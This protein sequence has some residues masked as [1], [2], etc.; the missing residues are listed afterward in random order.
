MSEPCDTA[1]DAPQLTTGWETETPIEDT[2]MR[3]AVFTLTGEVTSAAE[4]LGGRVARRP[5]LIAADL[6]RPAAFYNSAILLRPLTPERLE[7]TMAMLDAFF[8]RG[9]A[10]TGMVVLFSL[11]PTPDLRPFGW[12]LMG[13]PPIHLRPPGR[14]VPG[15]PPGVEIVRVESMEDAADWERTAIAGY[16][17]D[18]M[19][20]LPPG[21]VVAEAALHDPR[22]Y[23]WL[24]R[25][26]GRAAGASSAFVDHGIAYVSL[27]A[28]LP[29]A[30]GRGIG[31]ALTW[32]ATLADPSL[33]A[34]LLSSDDGRPVYE[35]MG[36]L[37]LM[38]L[39][40]WFRM[41]PGTP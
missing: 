35:R 5:D 33:P 41:R 6:G 32:R 11:W 8:D 34:M 20:S 2:L 12:H 22:H 16:P 26:D 24:A 28:T 21:S 39:T 40:L 1:P 7:D 14:I 17:F 29:E 36:Y 37:P 25:V 3:R 15:D 38:R 13:H 23:Y 10:S 18:D 4:Y 30:R 31:T 27:V 9:G 19:A